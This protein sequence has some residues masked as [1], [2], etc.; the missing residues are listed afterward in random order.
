MDLPLGCGD[1]TL[2]FRE[3]VGV[4]I[5]AVAN[6]EKLQRRAVVHAGHGAQLRRLRDGHHKRRGQH[7]GIRRAIGNES[8]ARLRQT[9]SGSVTPGPM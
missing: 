5:R 2:K 1:E 3:T 9:Q 7:H 4:V 6:P 8:G